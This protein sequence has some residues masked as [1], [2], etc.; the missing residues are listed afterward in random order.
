MIEHAELFQ[1]PQRVIKRQEIEQR[2]E[3]DAPRLARRCGE[4]DARRRRHRQ[5]RRVVLREVIA[6]EAGG[7]GRLQQSEAILVGLLQDFA[8]V[9]DVVENA[10][11]HVLR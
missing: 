7:L 4:K 5:R 8:A 6:V 10:E 1:E 3:P 11:L 9:I 2:A